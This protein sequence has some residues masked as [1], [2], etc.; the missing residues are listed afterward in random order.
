MPGAAYFTGRQKGV[1]LIEIL[2]AVVILAV[3]F[4]AAARMQVTGM[5]FSQGA[6]FESQAY[7][8]AGD[9]IAR[10]RANVAGVQAGGYDNLSTS[11]ELQSPGCAT[12]MC[13]PEAL[14]EQDIFDWS[15]HLHRES[16]NATFTPLLPSSADVTAQGTVTRMA[17]GGFSISIVWA[18]ENA[19]D[20]GQGSLRVDMFTEN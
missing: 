13:T 12:Q 18:D 20:I 9:I 5:R 1:G 11:G 19:N 15:E 2:I 4:L 6:Y 17:N 7:L 16:D 8:M 14:A 3:G 10:M